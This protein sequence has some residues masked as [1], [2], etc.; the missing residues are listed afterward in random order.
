[1]QGDNPTEPPATEVDSVSLRH[2]R[3][4]LGRR[5]AKAAAA[6][7]LVAFTLSG[8]ESIVWPL[9]EPLGGV[10]QDVIPVGYVA[11]AV[12]A[13][14]A[15]F[16]VSSSIPRAG[17]ARLKASAG[18]L[19]ITRGD[20][21]KWIPRER[22]ASGLVVPQTILDR[23]GRHSVEITLTNGDKLTAAVGQQIE[24]QSVLSALGIDAS[25][26]TAAVTLGSAMRPLTAGCVSFPLIVLALLF[27]AGEVSLSSSLTTPAT[28]ALSTALTLLV[29]RTFRPLEVIVGTDGVT[30]QKPWSTRF[31]PYSSIDDVKLGEDARITLKLS[32][33]GE[34]IVIL[35]GEEDV[36]RALYD[37]IWQAMH[38]KGDP[39]AE[40]LAELDRLE[41][42]GLRFADWRAELK[43]LAAPGA[44]YRK[45]A[46]PPELLAS[47]VEDPDAA[48]G[49]RI[50]AAL[51]LGS[52]DHPEAR[53]KIRA[54]AE[55][56]ASQR[57]RVALERAADDA[58][59]DE[60]LKRALEEAAEEEAAE[61]A[62]R[63][64]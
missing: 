35:D 47:V 52:S 62:E 6:S 4:G 30:L 44:G 56:C 29:L 57:V 14:L 49:R 27:I 15:R 51:A 39:Q 48:P 9:S 25:R 2:L 5:L 43:G 12:M 21:Q 26:R 60:T 13:I 37:R 53:V 59:D 55:A 38:V 10:L 33:S 31:I 16:C 42:R 36:R 22:V 11:A 64:A 7:F 28:I 18:G 17:P 19:E 50:G 58:L 8:L 41:P 24:A 61:A 34:P 46:V 23:I 40:A 63:R 32:R 20:Q 3:P 54:A 45:A 1:M